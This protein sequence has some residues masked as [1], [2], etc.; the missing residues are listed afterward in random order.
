MSG[1]VQEAYEIVEAIENWKRQV[2]E[3]DQRLTEQ[4][5]MIESLRSELEELKRSLLG[6]EGGEPRRG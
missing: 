2:M 5:K 3:R 4:A 6:I 1:K